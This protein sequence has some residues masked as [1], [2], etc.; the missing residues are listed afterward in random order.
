[1]VAIDWPSKV[2]IRKATRS[3]LPA[4]EWGGEYAHF[5]R[6]YADAFERAQRGDA[7]LWVAHLQDTDLIGQLFV[8]LE[9]IVFNSENNQANSQAYAYIYGFR[10]KPIFRNTGLGTRM[11]AITEADIHQQ[12]FRRVT[13]NVAKTNPRALEL[14]KRLGYTVTSEDPGR[15]SFPDEKGIWHHVDEPAWHMEK[16]LPK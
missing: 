12:G 8:H 5:R 10:I 14:Y 16:I 9:R 11:M 15:W 2:L 3:D 6:I 13:L 1:M 4:L 7:V